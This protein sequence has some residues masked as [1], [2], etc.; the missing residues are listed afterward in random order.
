MFIVVDGRARVSF[1][2]M[3]SLIQ[4]NINAL[5]MQMKKE[6]IMFKA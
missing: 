2:S 3:C 4:I 1:F 6:Q 5:H